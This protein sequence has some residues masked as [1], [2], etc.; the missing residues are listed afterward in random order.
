MKTC[1][2]KSELILTNCFVFKA[3]TIDFFV[4]FDL[5]IWFWLAE[6]GVNIDP[7]EEKNN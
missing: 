7:T 5:I 6:V 4:L 1:S 2:A 3:Y